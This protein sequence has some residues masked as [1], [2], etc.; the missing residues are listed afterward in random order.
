MPGYG[1]AETRDGL[2][3]WGW[4]EQR[5]TESYNYW[6][7]TTSEGG[8]P[9]SMPVWGVWL[10]GA[11]YF[12]TGRRTRKARNLARDARCVVTPEHAAEAVIV[13]GRA[14]EVTD[15]DLI[16]RVASTYGAKYPMGFPPGEPLFAVRP[17]VAFAVVDDED[18]F[19]STAT[20]WRF[21]N[22]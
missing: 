10:D 14:E 13:E 21:V 4:A 5:L 20:R 18:R 15:A 1:I 16:T 2:L 12:S 11:L 7:T 6:V 9:H 8:R 17:D 19:T 3:P 22:T